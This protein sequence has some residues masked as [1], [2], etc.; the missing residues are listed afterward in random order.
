MKEKIV[1]TN[2]VDEEIGD[3]D[4]QIQAYKEMLEC[5]DRPFD[6]QDE[7]LLEKAHD[8]A[9]ELVDAYLGDLLDNAEYSEHKEMVVIGGEGARWNGTSKVGG[10]DNNV[11][12]A[13]K[14]TLPD[15]YD[16]FFKFFVNEEGNF[17]YTEATHDCPM[18]GTYLVFRLMT[19]K[20][21]KWYKNNNGEVDNEMLIQHL[22]N[23]KCYTKRLAPDF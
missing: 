15:G 19:K 21:M 20:G 13:I 10:T 6:E 12:E 14:N 7:C 11:C 9:Y 17:A 18:G 16:A 5:N 1:Y 8:Y 22:L 2:D 4:Q 3:D 23:V